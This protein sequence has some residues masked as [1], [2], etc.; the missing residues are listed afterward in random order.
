MRARTCYLVGAGAGGAG[1]TRAPDLVLPTSRPGAARS[2]PA[3]DY[4]PMSDPSNRKPADYVFEDWQH[5]HETDP[6]AFELRRKEA[7]ESVI[8]SAPPDMQARL[9]GLQFR[10]DMERGRA[11]SNLAACLKAQSMMWDS[12][13]RLRDALSELSSVQQDGTLGAVARGRAEARKATVIP[14]RSAG[15]AVPAEQVPRDG[16]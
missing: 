16:E 15:R 1:L 10:V 11:G 12:L 4:L 14:F 2:L 9:R 5:L 7:L 13:V 8:Q 3:A 6:D